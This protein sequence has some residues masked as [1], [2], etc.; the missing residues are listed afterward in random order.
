MGPGEEA[1]VGVLG[2]DC[3]SA[4]HVRFHDGAIPKGAADLIAAH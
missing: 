4:M 3:K 1:W 2:M